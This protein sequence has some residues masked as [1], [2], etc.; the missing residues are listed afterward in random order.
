MPLSTR[1]WLFRSIVSLQ[2]E[3]CL[4]KV[5]Q[6]IVLTITVDVIEALCKHAVLQKPNVLVKWDLRPVS[7]KRMTL[8]ITP[9]QIPPCLFNH[10]TKPLINNHGKA[11]PVRLYKFLRATLASTAFLA[12]RAIALT[13]LRHNYLPRMQAYHIPFAP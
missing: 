10:F 2:T 12:D 13:T 4:T 11:R 8:H 1:P 6:P 3:G 7:A 9:H 5:F